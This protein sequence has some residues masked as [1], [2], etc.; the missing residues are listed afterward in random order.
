[1]SSLWQDLR[2]GWR[3][4][5]R[6]PGFTALVVLVMALGIGTNTLVFNIVDALLI[7]PIPF[8]DAHRNVRIYSYDKYATSVSERMDGLSFLDFR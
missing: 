1:M 6:T 2:I 7:R 3:G 5:M 4:L 8:Q